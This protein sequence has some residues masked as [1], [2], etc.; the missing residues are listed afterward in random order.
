MRS[1]YVAEIAGHLTT[2]I[3]GTEMHVRAC[4]NAS[5]GLQFLSSRY[6]CSADR[7]ESGGTR[8]DIQFVARKHEQENICKNAQPNQILSLWLR[9][10]GREWPGTPVR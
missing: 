4:D 10:I 9:L 3:L 7:L 5:H 2:S 1:L 6:I 8:I